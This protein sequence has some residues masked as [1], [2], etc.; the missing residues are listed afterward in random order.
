MVSKLWL[1]SGGNSGT[2][3]SQRESP[4]SQ[5]VLDSERLHTGGY[6]FR[7]MWQVKRLLSQSWN[8][9]TAG[10]EI[11]LQQLQLFFTS[12]ERHFR[13]SSQPF[14]ILLNEELMGKIFPYIRWKK[15]KERLWSFL[16]D[17]SVAVSGKF[18]QKFMTC[19]QYDFFSLSHRMLQFVLHI[20]FITLISLHMAP[21]EQG[22]TKDSARKSWI[23]FPVTI[24]VP[25]GKVFQILKDS[26][27]PFGK[28]G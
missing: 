5:F 16:K 4:V 24:F 13:N 23:Y 3:H 8:L 25:I 19:H 9:T 21:W 22:Q 28:W 20:I 14:N 17:M 1:G 12:K 15:E 7:A 2:S 27:S 10:Q 6:L 18:P 11:S 26:L